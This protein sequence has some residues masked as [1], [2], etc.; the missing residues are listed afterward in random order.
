MIKEAVG[1]GKTVDEA[2]LE[3]GYAIDDAFLN[4]VEEFAIV[5]GRG[6]GALR[7]AVRSY[8]REHPQ[9]LGYRSGSISEGGIG[10]T[11]VKLK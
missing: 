8:V 6:T 10:V 7:Q 9:V 5:H 11:V 2:L 4:G 3:L 1:F